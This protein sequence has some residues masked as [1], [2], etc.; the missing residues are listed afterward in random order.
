MDFRREECYISEI[1]AVDRRDRHLAKMNK[2]QLQRTLQTSP[3]RTKPNWREMINISYQEQ[4]ALLPPVTNQISEFL[5]RTQTKHTRTSQ[6]MSLSEHWTKLV[7]EQPS[8]KY[9]KNHPLSLC[10][11]LLL[12]AAPEEAA[13]SR[14]SWKFEKKLCN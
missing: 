5:T 12:V 4:L 14:K 2:Q 7:L 13:S 1:W 6:W 11:L 10:F 9:S 3:A 8:L